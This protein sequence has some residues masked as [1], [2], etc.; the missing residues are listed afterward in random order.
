MTPLS[1]LNYNPILH[2]LSS[3]SFPTTSNASVPMETTTASDLFDQESGD[4]HPKQKG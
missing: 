1:G 2:P 4:F 3:Y